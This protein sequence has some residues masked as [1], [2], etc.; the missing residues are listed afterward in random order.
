[1]A[2]IKVQKITVPIINI[3]YRRPTSSLAAG[4]L[5]YNQKD[6]VFY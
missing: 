2:E 6:R 5:A 1:M 3:Q 4:Q